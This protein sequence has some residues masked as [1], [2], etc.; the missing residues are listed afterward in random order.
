MSD[1]TSRL[2]IEILALKKII[3]AL[4][5]TLSSADREMLNAMLANGSGEDVIES[6]SLQREIQVEI[7]KIL[8]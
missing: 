7:N 2:A 1:T 6:A 3:T 5:A 8:L 4:Y